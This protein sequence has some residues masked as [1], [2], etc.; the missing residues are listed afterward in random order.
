MSSVGQFAMSSS[1]VTVL[2]LMTTR[3][4]TAVRVSPTVRPHPHPPAP[5]AAVTA[6]SPTQL[7]LTSVDPDAGGWDESSRGPGTVDTEPLPHAARM[8]RTRGTNKI[9]SG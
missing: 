4:R 3:H 9:E 7:A 8:R 6:A 2:P 1:R 5:E